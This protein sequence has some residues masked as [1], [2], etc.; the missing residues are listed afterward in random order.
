MDRR[1]FLAN[2]A[3]FL[4]ST[5]VKIGKSNTNGI[6]EMMHQSKILKTTSNFEREKLRIPFGFKGAYLSEL[7]QS[8]VLLENARGDK[9]LGL[10]TQSV[11]Y[12]DADLFAMTSEA[13]GNSQMFVLTNMAL[14]YIKEKFLDCPIKLFDEL[15]PWLLEEGKKITNNPNLN[16]NF[17][18]NALVSVDNAMWMLYAKQK[19]IATF[20]SLIPSSYRSAFSHKNDR[21]AVMFQISYD[22][23]LSDIQNAA[24]AGYFVFKIK[25]GSPG[26]QEE[27]LQQ[28]KRRLK[29][30]HEVLQYERRKGTKDIYYTMDANGR[31]EKKETLQSYLAYAKEIDAFEYIILYEEP[32]VEGN[33]DSVDDLGVLVGADESIHNEEDAYRKIKLGYKAFIL[34]GIAK[35]L[36]QTIK[37]AQ[38]AYQNNIPCLCSDLTVNPILIDWNKIIA[39][40]LPPFPKLAM[41]LM[42]TNGDMNYSNWEEMKKKHPYKNASWTQ[43][44]DGM[45]H[46]NQEFFDVAGGI[47]TISPYYQDMLSKTV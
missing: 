44:E 12:G 13:C 22:M 20:T 15:L 33:N 8:V 34:K 21:I 43:V 32:F 42:E 3:V 46:L 17:V 31:Y 27:M 39:A 30:I 16:I 37:I 45:F 7:W 29:E 1:C 14:N 25:T 41:G 11:L 9:G 10:A 47:F 38:V 19:Q 6:L 40:T 23:P 24:K 36:S 2:S 18:Y 35:T 4:I 28:D 26:N 5:K